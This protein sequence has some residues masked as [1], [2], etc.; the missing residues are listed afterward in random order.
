MCLLKIYLNCIDFLC[1]FDLSLTQVHSEVP[2]R[3]WLPESVYKVFPLLVAS[4]GALGCMLGSA[5][6]YALGGV[7]LVYSGG[8]YC[9]RL[10]YSRV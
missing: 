2:M 6:G 10:Q 9:M 4:I 1:V 7:L 8:V 5:A 3:L